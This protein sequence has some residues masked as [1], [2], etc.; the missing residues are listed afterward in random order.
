ML[1]AFVGLPRL[2]RSSFL[3]AERRGVE[4]RA[5]HHGAAEPRDVASKRS[6]MNKALRNSNDLLKIQL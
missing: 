5:V 1:A 4:G 2:A 6:R 3:L